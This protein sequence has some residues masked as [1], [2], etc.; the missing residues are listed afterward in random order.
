[1]ESTDMIHAMQV[2]HGQRAPGH[3]ISSWP[4]TAPSPMHA[5][6][7]LHPGPLGVPYPGYV[8][9]AW[10]ASTPAHSMPTTPFQ[11]FQRDF[12]NGQGAAAGGGSGAQPGTSQQRQRPMFSNELFVP[13]STGML[14]SFSPYRLLPFQSDLTCFECNATA[15]HYGNECPLR[16][17][18]VRGEAPPGWI[19]TGPGSVSKN[20]AAWNGSELTATAR[21]E[22]ATFVARH[23]LV[24][25]TNQPVSVE[26]ITAAEPVTARRPL[27][28]LGQRR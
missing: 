11:T 18:R 26:E 20:P 16:F 12:A 25:H 5:Y 15:E 1:M 22:Y 14:G 9:P 3:I 28:R 21:A 19:I 27:P 7:P 2:Q 8:S 6:P 4:Y 10:A 17:A 13:Y 24:A 23:G